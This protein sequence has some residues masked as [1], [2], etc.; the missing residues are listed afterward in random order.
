MSCAEKGRRKRQA[1]REREARQKAAKA[2]KVSVLQAAKAALVA[3][4]AAGAPR[5]PP[6]PRGV[7]RKL[8]AL[9]G[10][11]PAPKKQKWV[12]VEKGIFQ[13]GDAYY[14]RVKVDGKDKCGK[15]RTTLEEARNDYDAL[16]VEQKAAAKERKRKRT[17]EANK[18]KHGDACAKERDAAWALRALVAAKWEVLVLNDGTRADVL[19]RP[20]GATV[21]LWLPIQL[22][23]ASQADEKKGNPHWPFQHCRG[24]EGMAMLFWALDGNHLWVLHDGRK[25]TTTGPCLYE[26]DKQ[27]DGAWYTWN[28]AMKKTRGTQSVEDVGAALATAWHACPWRV[29]ERTARRDIKNENA[30][31]ELEG[32]EAWIK[33]VLKPTGVAGDFPKDQNG[34]YDYRVEDLLP[35]KQFKTAHKHANACGFLVDLRKLCGDKKTRPYDEGDFDELIVVLVNEKEDFIDVWTIPHDVLL[36][37]GTKTNNKTCYLKTADSVNKGL[38]A[39]TVHLP[40]ALDTDKRKPKVKGDGRPGCRPCQTLW[41]REHHTR[42]RF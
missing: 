4:A 29:K 23:T 36:A 42:V 41:T 39:L 22:K 27:P 33:H 32:I 14:A 24:Y 8:E 18:A 12:K 7:K 30:R 11:A 28:K 3:V 9:E 25:M 38:T 6:P 20:R 5:I 35:R 31:T 34:S 37:K 26:K 16:L 21:D 1:A 10:G 19:V 40:E 17:P 15:T 13:L 2:A